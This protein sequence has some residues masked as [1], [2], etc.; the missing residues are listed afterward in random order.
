MSKSLCTFSYI[1]AASA[2]FIHEETIMSFDNISLYIDAIICVVS[3]VDP[4]TILETFL[5]WCSVSPTFILSGEYPTK[6]LH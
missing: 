5:I 3:G 1:L 4:E 2:T 6:S